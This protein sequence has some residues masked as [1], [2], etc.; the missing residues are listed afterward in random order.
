[1]SA[2]LNIPA[3]KID[4]MAEY[5][6]NTR[7][8]SNSPMVYIAKTY[9]SALFLVYQATKLLPKYRKNYTNHFTL[10]TSNDTVVL[11]T[12]ETSIIHPSVDAILNYYVIKPTA[13]KRVSR[14]HWCISFDT[15]EF[16]NK[17]P[18]NFI[19]YTLKSSGEWWYYDRGMILNGYST[20]DC[21]T[22]LFIYMELHATFRPVCKPK[23]ALFQ[24]M[25]TLP[26]LSFLT[27]A[28]DITTSLFTNSSM[29][30]RQPINNIINVIQSPQQTPARVE[31]NSV[32]TQTFANDF[33]AANTTRIITPTTISTTVTASVA[34]ITHDVFTVSPMMTSSAGVTAPSTSTAAQLPLP[35][36]PPASPSL[37]SSSLQPINAPLLPPVS[38]AQSPLSIPTVTTIP[39]SEMPVNLLAQPVPIIRNENTEMATNE[40]LMAIMPSLDWLYNRQVELE[41]CN[42]NYFKPHDLNI[43]NCDLNTDQSS[44]WLSSLK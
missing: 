1:M 32:P 36:P 21:P 19:G 25:F 39:A 31:S 43:P 20:T 30:R 29:N 4:L 37:P 7:I 18:D 15:I 23:T 13:S 42:I 28:P 24:S 8:F 44:N 27:P 6:V 33:A 10:F 38:I 35:T 40:K 34:P 41:K 2:L 11:V 22:S 16:S 17:K 3:D 5:G 26:S 9:K 12:A 14:W